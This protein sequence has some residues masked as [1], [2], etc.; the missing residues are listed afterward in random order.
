MTKTSAKWMEKETRLERTMS[1]RKK[2]QEKNKNNGRENS[3]AHAPI[4]QATKSAFR[5]SIGK[6]GIS[7][8]RQFA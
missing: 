1:E 2:V 8:A 4:A 5:M 7:N 3:L 6:P